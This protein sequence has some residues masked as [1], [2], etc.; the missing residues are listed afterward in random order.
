MVTIG[1]AKGW[2]SSERY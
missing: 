2:M 1:H